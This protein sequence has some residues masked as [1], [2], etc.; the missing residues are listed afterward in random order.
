MKYYC[1]T[2]VD[3][4]HFIYAIRTR[5]IQRGIPESVQLEE[6]RPPAYL[7][8]LD[9]CSTAH[10]YIRCAAV[11]NSAAMHTYAIGFLFFLFL[12]CASLN[13]NIGAFFC[14]SLKVQS[15][16]TPAHVSMYCTMLFRS[17]IF[18]SDIFCYELRTPLSYST[19][20]LYKRQRVFVFFFFL[21]P[22]P[23]PFL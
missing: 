4:S 18:S 6:F 9:C 1:T 3:V 14:F 12:S 7:L 20:A 16:Q 11:Q 22:P 23:P 19:H 13:F 17:D 5:R 8:H 15:T 10:Q 21:L 2:T